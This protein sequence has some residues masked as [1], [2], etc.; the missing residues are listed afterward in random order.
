MICTRA[1]GAPSLGCPNNPPTLRPRSRC[2]RRPGGKGP[3]RERGS[4]LA[5]EVQI[6]MEVVHGR[7]LG[8]EHLMAE[9]E[10]SE[11]T[12]AEV[13]AGVA[14]AVVLDRTRVAGVRG[15]AD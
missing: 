14:R 4:N 6:E 11:R 13:R 8:A 2:C 1:G 15:I 9:Y 12:T 3:F 10:V 5:H 7:E